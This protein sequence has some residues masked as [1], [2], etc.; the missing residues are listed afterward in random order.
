MTTNPDVKLTIKTGRVL[1]HITFQPADAGM[2]YEPW[3]A[4]HT[5]PEMCTPD[6]IEELWNAWK[7]GKTQ[8]DIVECEMEDF[9]E[10]LTY[11]GYI[12]TTSGGSMAR[13]ETI[14]DRD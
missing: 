9:S 1:H 10:H 8:D 12:I 5:D 2:H 4:L 3:V 6:H 13:L 11:L 7:E 14:G